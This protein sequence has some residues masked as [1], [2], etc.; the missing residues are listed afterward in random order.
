MKHFAKIAALVLGISTVASA[1]PIRTD[2][3]RNIDEHVRDQG[4]R[5]LG[6]WVPLADHYSA[7]GNEQAITVGIGAGRFHRLRIEAERGR[8]F[9]RAL[10][11]RFRDGSHQ[12]ITLDRMLRAGESTVV[13]L[14]GGDRAIERILVRTQSDPRAAY[15]IMAER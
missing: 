11:V 7:T 8:P 15:T 2:R 9:L 1:Q 12:H 3:D 13:D 14:N 5:A 6:N 4:D 10:D